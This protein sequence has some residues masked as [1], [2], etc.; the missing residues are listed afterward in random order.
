MEEVK[1]NSGQNLGIASS[2]NGRY[3]ICTCSYTLCRVNSNN[4]RDYMLLYWLA[5]DF[6]MRHATIHHEGS[7]L[8]D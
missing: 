1:N 8:Q 7:C 3:N 6:H 5:S 2:D 4:T